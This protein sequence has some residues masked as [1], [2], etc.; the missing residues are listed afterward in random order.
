VSQENVE[1]A[2]RAHEA[3]SHPRVDGFDLDRFYAHADPNLVIDWSRSRGV[4]AGVY[5]GEAQTR[6]LWST[7][8]EVFDRVVVEPLEFI[9][10]GDHVVVPHHLRASGRDGLTVDARAVVVMTLREGRIVELRLYQTRAEAR[11][12]VGLEE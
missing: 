8:F 1:I 3:F 11:K 12:A 5:Q 9:E 10:H 2:R 6:G 4:E 7:F